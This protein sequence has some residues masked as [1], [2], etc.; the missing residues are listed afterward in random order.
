MPTIT[1]KIEYVDD[2][3]FHTLAEGVELT[4]PDDMGTF[5]A[6]KQQHTWEAL[7]SQRPD[8]YDKVPVYNKTS[9]CG[10]CFT[11]TDRKP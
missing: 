9:R 8:I 1:F 7:R 6:P 5:P 4:F 2:H 11:I 10:L 3:G